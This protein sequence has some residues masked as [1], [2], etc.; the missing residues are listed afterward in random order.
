M[1]KKIDTQLELLFAHDLGEKMDT[2]LGVLL[3]GIPAFAGWTH[4]EL[5]VCKIPHD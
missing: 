1:R 5:G 2:E 3:R 4:A